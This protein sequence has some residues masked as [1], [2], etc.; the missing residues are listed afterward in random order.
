M[1]KDEWKCKNNKRYIAN[2][3]FSKGQDGV[4]SRN[5]IH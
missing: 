3:Q 2:G 1:M 4:D 5:V